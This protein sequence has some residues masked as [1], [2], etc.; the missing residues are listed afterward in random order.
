MGTLD[1]DPRA[2]NLILSE[3]FDKPTSKRLMQKKIQKK[4]KQGLLTKNFLSA[5]GQNQLE[6]AYRIFA[7]N[8][9]LGKYDWWGW[10]ARS[11]WAYEL[12]TLPWMMPRWDGKPCNLLILAEQGLG[13]EVLFT[14]A[15]RDLLKQAGTV[16]W[17]IDSRLLPIYQRSIPEINWISRWYG[18]PVGTSLRIDHPRPKYD[19]FIPAGNVPKL[20]RTGPS[21]FPKEPFLKPNEERVAFWKAKYEGKRGFLFKAG[22]ANEKMIAPKELGQPGDVNLQHDVKLPWAENPEWED[23]DDYI[24]LLASLK[25][26]VAVPSAVVH[27]CG[28]IGQTC[29]VIKPPK[30]VVNEY[31]NTMLKWYY[32]RGKYMDWYGPHVRLYESL[33]EFKS[34]QR[35]LSKTERGTA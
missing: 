23:M 29:H 24:A 22:A 10:E 18:Q 16:T 31:R 12:S 30:K 17:E 1:L 7:A 21:T 20:Y 11:P 13:D 2:V 3:N 14:T 26:V 32:P 34:D 8:M 4:A 19:A 5:P 28:A 15:A 33:Y 25:D 9:M 35:K 6:W 27:L